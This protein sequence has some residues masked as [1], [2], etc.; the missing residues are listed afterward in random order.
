MP[1]PRIVG[2]LCLSLIVLCTGVAPT[3]AAQQWIPQPGIVRANLT[4][5][6]TIRIGSRLRTYSVDRGVIVFAESDNG[7]DL[8]Q[9][10]E[11]NI[12]ASGQQG[13]SQASIAHPAVVQRS[14]GRFVM[15]Y[16]ATTQAQPP[17]LPRRMFVR[18]SDNGTTFGPPAPLPVTA[19]DINPRGLTVQFTP[20]VV[21]M[22]DGS[23]RLYYTAGGSDI[24]SMRSTDGGETWVPDAGY[25]LGQLP[26]PGQSRTA[27]YVAPDAVVQSDGSVGLYLAYGEFES[28]CGGLGCLAIRLAVSTDGI[29]F[30][31]ESGMLIAPTGGGHA[32]IDPD[33]F[34]AADGRWY[35]LYGEEGS[36]AINLRL[37][38]RT[39]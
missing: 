1:P 8:S 19:L 31:L 36:G 11:T 5:T 20:D 24:G 13:D 32:V 7:R 6:S 23:L 22:P 30:T 10:T 18:I 37:A 38:T 33:V 35:M 26:G 29:V 39:E 25:R 3:I 16:T 21:R 28:R 2:S 34:Q 14:D 4:S 12:R 9:T 27:A 15:V 17:L